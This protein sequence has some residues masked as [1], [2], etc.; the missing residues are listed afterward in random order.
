MASKKEHNIGGE[1][2]DDC[3]TSG[4]SQT[5]TMVE[6]S[7]SHHFFSFLNVDVSSSLMCMIVSVYIEMCVIGKRS[8]QEGGE[9]EKQVERANTQKTQ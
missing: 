9:E 5:E 6:R 7:T 3:M 2:E 1:E 8:T 4:I